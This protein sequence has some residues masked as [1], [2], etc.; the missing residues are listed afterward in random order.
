ML[1]FSGDKKYDEA[2]PAV[3]FLRIR[4][5]LEVKSRT[6]S[7]PR[8][9]DL[10]FSIIQFNF[11]TT[12]TLGTEQSGLCREVETRVNVWTVRQKRDRCR[13]VEIRI[14]VWTVRQKSGRCREVETRVSVWIVRQK[15]WPLERGGRHIPWTLEIWGFDFSDV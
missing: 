4:E 7:C 13:E 8:P 9:R 6:S 11:S 12:A 14:N 10:R 15:K 1:I 2:F 3:Y 5:K